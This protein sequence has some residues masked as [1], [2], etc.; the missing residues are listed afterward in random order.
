MVLLV[1]V[2]LVFVLL[3]HICDVSMCDASICDVSSICDA[4]DCDTCLVML[5]VVISRKVVV[6]CLFFIFMSGCSDKRFR[7][8]N[9]VLKIHN[10]FVLSL[11]C[12]EI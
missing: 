8:A 7:Y 2:I 3:V 1:F 11:S 6:Y 12:Y 10:A 5:V 4:G 9:L